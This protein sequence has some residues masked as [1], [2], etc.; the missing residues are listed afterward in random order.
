MTLLL[1]F[2]TFIYAGRVIF[3]FIGFVRERLR[4]THA[5]FE[6]SVTIVVPA[7]NEEK[8]IERCVNSLLQVDY[9][10]EMLEIIVVDDRS[11]D[12]TGE[13]LNKLSA[14]TNELR[15]IHR[16]DA[17]ED[18]NL[19]GKSGALQ[20]GISSARSEI[21]LLTDADCIVHRSWVH[22]IVAQFSDPNVG[23]VCALTSVTSHTFLEKIQDVEWTYTQT[24]A[25]G[26]LGNNIPLGCFGNNMAVRKSVFDEL[27]G[28]KNIPFS[29][30][31][32]M[33]LQLAIHDAGHRVRYA[34]GPDTKVETLPCYTI[35]EYIKQRHRW[36]RGGRALKL[37]GMVFVLSSLALWLGIILSVAFDELS[38]FTALVS[39]RLLG[40][41]ALI[42]NTAIT[43]RRYS[44]LPYIVPSMGILWLTELAIPFIALKRTV[45]WKGQSFK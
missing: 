28:Y 32:D 16:T 33:A 14:R 30:T 42:G 13:L 35:S 11:T 24:M 20:Q 3:F 9:P 34:V 10:H 12:R 2:L 1:P 23:S 7:R 8:N 38:W 17:D 39:L 37:R 26:G 31:E 19:R 41:S 4:S 5:P 18:H 44:L 43:I 45:R 36:I 29:V 15:I 22:G 27:G 25:A 6:P 40:D 21:V